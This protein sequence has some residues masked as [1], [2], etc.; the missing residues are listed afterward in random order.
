MLSTDCPLH[1]KAVPFIPSATCV[2]DPSIIPQV[3][4]TDLLAHQQTYRLG[5]LRGNFTRK[6]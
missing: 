2:P 1:F 4:D 6:N 3:D 5:Q